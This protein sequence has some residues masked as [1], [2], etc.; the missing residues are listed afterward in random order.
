MFEF[1]VYTDIYKKQSSG[2]AD[3]Q[4]QCDIDQAAACAFHANQQ[5]S[6]EA[7]S[8]AQMLTHRPN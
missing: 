4:K 1:W 3:E 6:N 5:H 2:A 7:F 8:T